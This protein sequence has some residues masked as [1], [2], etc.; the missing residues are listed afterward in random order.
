MRA[1]AARYKSSMRRERQINRK[2]K[3]FEQKILRDFKM[4]ETAQSYCMNRKYFAAAAAILAV[5][6]AVLWV[7]YG[8]EGKTRQTFNCAQSIPTLAVLPSNEYEEA[9]SSGIQTYPADAQTT[10]KVSHTTEKTVY[11]TFDDGPSDRI[12]P[13][14][15]D[16][17]DSEN[18]KA[19]FFIV[20]QQAERRRYLIRR[21]AE[22]GHTV[23][24]HSYT[25]DYKKIYRSPQSLIEDIDRC[26]DVIESITGRRSC[27]YRFPGGSYGL[28]S[29]IIAA[30]AEHGMRY[31]DWNASTRDAEWGAGGT[32]DLYRNAVETSA[33]C[34]NIVLLSHDS[35]D[36]KYT[37]EATR[38]IIKYYKQKGYTFGTF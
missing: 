29:D 27:V 30:A 37:P 28:K 16:I 1:S 14:I 10:E 11:L 35:T 38:K 17:L 32:D 22:S 3:K 26:N 9:F 24:V 15:L 8:L 2:N 34:N 18:V 12:T 25:H 13:K 36:K 4:T 19:T 6:F 23:A 33:N 21:E 5:A 7:A 20:G 31:V